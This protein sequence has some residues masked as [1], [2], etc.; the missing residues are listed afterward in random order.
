MVIFGIL[1]E[2]IM[3]FSNNHQLG[4][5]GESKAKEYLLKNGYKI[6]KENYRIYAG[7]IDLITIN[8]N[9]I[10][11]IEVKT[12]CSKKYGLPCEAVDFNKKNRIRKIALYFLNSNCNNHFCKYKKRFDVITIMVE[13]GKAR[14][15]HF[16]N[17][18]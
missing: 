12:R 9:Y 3:Q 15:K 8:Q 18:F 16:K 7:E 14:L 2:V 11:F 5:W 13:Q 4:N 10:V 17:A 1:M 6:I